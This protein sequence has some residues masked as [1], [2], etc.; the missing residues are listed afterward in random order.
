MNECLYKIVCVNGNDWWHWGRKWIRMKLICYS[1]ICVIIC[2]STLALHFS[3]EMTF[4]D[5]DLSKLMFLFMRIARTLDLLI[6]NLEVRFDSIKNQKWKPACINATRSDFTSA[7]LKYEWIG[8]NKIWINFIWWCG[9]FEY[10][11]LCEAIQFI[12]SQGRQQNT[13]LQN[14]YI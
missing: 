4:C 14:K 6:P 12:L 9:F 1:E 5:F 10:W 2:I 7:G 3:F 11:V 13:K 8:R